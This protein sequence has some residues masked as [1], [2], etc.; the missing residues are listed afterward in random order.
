MLKFRQ[1]FHTTKCAV[2]GMVHVGALPG[3]PLCNKS[4]DSLVFKACKEAEMY[5]KYGLDSILV[6]N[7]HDVPYIQSK[8]FT[9]ETVATMTRVCTEIRKIAPGTV[10]CGVQVLACG[11]LE[12]LAVAKACN[13]D[14]IRA[15][16]FVFGHVADEGYTDANAGLI[17]RYRRQIQAENV[18]ILADIKKK[19]SSHAITSD[20]SLVETAQA[21]QFFQADG[22]ILTGVATGSPANVSELS[23]VKKFCSLPVLVGSGVTGDNLGDYMGADGVIVGSYFKKGGVW[24]EDV[25]EERVRN[26]MEKRKIFITMALKLLF[27]VAICLTRTVLCENSTENFNETET[28]P[29]DLYVIKTV[30][31]EVGILTD[32]GNDTNTND[33]HEQVDVSFFDPSQNGTIDLSNIPLPIQT[34][35]SGVSVTGLLPAANL[36]AILVPPSDGLP[37]LPKKQVTVTQNI[38]TNNPDKGS[39]IIS[40]LPKLLGLTKKNESETRD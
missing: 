34:N 8:Y 9:P 33:T 1:L 25:D 21:A 31:Y 36:A 14:F 13:F 18:L 40:N 23:Q 5:L 38:S 30:V 20:V 15:E 3:T 17:L 7:M 10:P 12:A 22:L 2:V 6:E 24:Y 27:L 37:V 4:V 29:Q 16:G 11:N 32:A 39:E 26:F 19:H 35:V 28:A